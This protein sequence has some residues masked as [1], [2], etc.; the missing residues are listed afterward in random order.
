MN[1]R[2][3]LQTLAAGLTGA[4]L[5]PERLLWVPGQKTIFLPSVVEPLGNEFEFMDWLARE[6]LRILKNEL[7]VTRAVNR[8]FDAA[9]QRSFDLGRVVRVA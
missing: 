7:V 1:R 4:A 2:A 9:Y 8:S 6:G 3:F 5:D